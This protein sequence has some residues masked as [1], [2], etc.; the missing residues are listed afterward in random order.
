M[1][2]K[3]IKNRIK[4]LVLYSVFGVAMMFAVMILVFWITEE[5]AN[6][7]PMGLLIGVLVGVA[8][9]LF[10]DAVAREQNK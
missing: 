8:F 4:I 3:P 9:K 7:I 2:K 6:L 10:N 1:D 5:I